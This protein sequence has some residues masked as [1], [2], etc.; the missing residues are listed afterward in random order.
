MFW[1]WLCLQ[2]IF[3]LDTELSFNKQVF[4]WI[5]CLLLPLTRPEGIL[6]SAFAF[7]YLQFIDTERV[8][9]DSIEMGDENER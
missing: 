5:L 3:L 2:V 6:V 1:F 4:L 7:F 9:H 8:N